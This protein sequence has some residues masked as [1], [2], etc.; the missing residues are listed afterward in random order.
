MWTRQH[1]AART[2]GEAAPRRPAGAEVVTDSVRLAGCAF[3]SPGRRPTARCGPPPR[4][5]VGGAW[6]AAEHGRARMMI[7]AAF[8]ATE[9]ADLAGQ[10]EHRV[11][12]DRQRQAR[13]PA[14]R[15][16]ASAVESSARILASPRSTVTRLVAPRKVTAVHGP[17]P[18]A[19]S[20][21]SWDASRHR[22]RPRQRHHLAVR[23]LCPPAAACGRGRSA[24]RTDL[25][26][27]PV[28]QA[29]EARHERRLRAGVD[30]GRAARAAQAARPCMTPTRSAIG[31]RLLLVVGDEQRGDAHLELDPPDLA[32][33]AALAPGRPAR[34]AARRAAATCGSM[35]RARARAT[36][37]CWPPDICAGTGSACADS[38]TS[39]S[40]ST[41]R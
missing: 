24:G 36:R 34:R 4:G 9:T 5:R 32:S 17:R 29:D 2:I 8:S 18:A 12:A 37:C 38:P 16:A 10:H 7:A 23:R 15:T 33:A 20:G 6:S 40:I 3:R 22:F 14:G 13:L 26:G 27:Q 30:L 11:G 41:A 39:S 28:R 21:A 35:A 1:G 31:Q 19:G 25:A